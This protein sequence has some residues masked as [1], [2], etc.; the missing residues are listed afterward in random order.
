[1]L[2][3]LM[4]GL[5]ALKAIGDYGQGDRA[6][7]AQNILNSQTMAREDTRIQRT[8][9]DAKVAGVHPMVAM[10]IPSPTAAMRVGDPPKSDV[11]FG[12]SLLRSANYSIAKQQE[13]LMAAQASK[14]AAEETN[15]KSN[16]VLNTINAAIAANDLSVLSKSPYTTSKDTN[17]MG[18]VSRATSGFGVDLK[19]VLDNVFGKKRMMSDAEFKEFKK[20]H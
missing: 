17:M 14:V 13:K 20:K 19:K 9:A 7:N 5:S 11:D 8:M 3:W 6:Y 15:V 16:T 10:G 18:T 4:A 12:E 2:D 1:M